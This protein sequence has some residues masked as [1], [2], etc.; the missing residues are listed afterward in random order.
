MAA[1]CGAWARLCPLLALAALAGLGAAAKVSGAAGNGS[2]WCLP[3]LF[4][5]PGPFA[6]VEAAALCPRDLPGSSPG[7]CAGPSP[8]TRL[9]V[10][11]R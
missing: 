5:V 4:P 8:G 10:L 2:R 11:P 9:S 7:A 6:P 3:P 1:R